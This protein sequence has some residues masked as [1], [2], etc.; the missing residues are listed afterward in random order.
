MGINI[1][2]KTDYSFLFS[3][4][5]TSNSGSTSGNSFLADYAAIKNGSYGKLMKAYYSETKNTTINS[6]VNSKNTDDAKT[7]S[8][9]QNKADSLK[10]SADALLATGSKSV[11]ENANIDK[12]YNSVSQFI[13]NY[14]SLIKSMD[15]VNSTS[16][17]G[18]ASNLTNTTLSNQSSLSKIGIKIN[19]DH[20]LSIN[21]DHF[22]SSNMT[23]IKSLF[24]GN[25]SYAYNVSSQASF[26]DLAANNQMSKINTYGTNG[27]FNT[28]N[29]VG[30]LF[31]S[32]L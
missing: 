23:S 16:I 9:V 31:N 3:S 22:K 25:G 5:H 19:T 27:S 21:E 30:N 24:Q 7:L 28:F 8:S 15:D 20:T 2:N 11:F 4:F 32:Y 18:K 6:L 29:Q 1:Q 10:E 12:I 14:N 13:E 17:L 26:I